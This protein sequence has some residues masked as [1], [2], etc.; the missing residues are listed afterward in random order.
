[1]TMLNVCVNLPM[2]QRFIVASRVAHGKKMGLCYEIHGTK[3]AIQFDQEDQSNI[4]LYRAGKFWIPANL[5]AL[6]TG[7]MQCFPRG[8]ATVLAT[9]TRSSLSRSLFINQFWVFSRRGPL[10]QMD[11]L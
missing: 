1:M 10:F 9:K 6:G 3:G 8:L 7:V 5:Q 11:S 4:Y 2:A